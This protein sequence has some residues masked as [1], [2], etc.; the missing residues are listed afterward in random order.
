MSTVQFAAVQ[1]DHWPQTTTEMSIPIAIET[2]KQQ[3][4]LK[5]P[6][7][8][9]AWTLKRVKYLTAATS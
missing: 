5:A 2:T 8:L 9:E 6:S 3:Q 7:D 4:Q 1:S